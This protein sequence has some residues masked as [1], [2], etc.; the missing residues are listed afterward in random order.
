LDSEY[1]L[2]DYDDTLVGRGDSLPKASSFNIKAISLLNDL[3]QVAICTGNTIRSVRLE[4]QVTAA[5]RAETSVSK[6]LV[7]FADGGVN[8]Y[9]CSLYDRDGRPSVLGC[10]SEC[11]FPDALFATAGSGNV[12]EIVQWLQRAGIPA[13]RIDNRDDALIAIKPI[14]KEHR[15]AFICL[16]RYIIRDLIDLEVRESGISTVE[17]HKKSLSKVHALKYLKQA[18][19]T[20]SLT[21][22]YVGDECFSGNDRDIREFSGVDPTVK[23]LQVSS[24]AT[25]S[26]FLSTLIEYIKENDQR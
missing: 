4:T 6:P 1:F 20:P 25:T 24:L 8:K 3:S 17:I 10:L 26:F 5:D 16:V 9:C 7:V 12:N 18:S 23:C 11:I 22:T 13:R 2:F 14:E 19:S 21:M 15:R